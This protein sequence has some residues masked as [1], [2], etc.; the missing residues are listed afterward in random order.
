MKARALAI[1][2]VLVSSSF[3]F[4][5]DAHAQS[6][7]EVQAAR[8]AFAEGLKFEQ[9]HRY[10]DALEKFTRVKEVK[11]TPQVRYRIATCLVGL[12]KL[13]EGRDTFK[14]IQP[15]PGNRDEEDTAQASSDVL[16]TLAPRIPASHP[17]ENCW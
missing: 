11:D 8:D 12:G 7:A 9:A 2:V 6:E 1:A 10:Q 13:R 4:A 17:H 14:S 15:H 16:K 5:L 3:S